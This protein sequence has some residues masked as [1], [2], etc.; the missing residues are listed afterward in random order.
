MELYMKSACPF[1]NDC[2]N[3]EFLNALCEKSKPCS[4]IYTA[5]HIY[6]EKSERR[7]AERNLPQ[8]TLQPSE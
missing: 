4:E 5:C 2:R 1:S 6:R 7:A 3:G 8:N